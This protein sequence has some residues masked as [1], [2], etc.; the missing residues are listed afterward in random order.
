MHAAHD[1]LRAH[2]ADPEQEAALKQA[3]LTEDVRKARGTEVV[4]FVRKCS[5]DQLGAFM[6]QAVFQ[7]EEAELTEDV[8]KAREA[9]V[10]EFV[11]EHSKD[12]LVPFV[13]AIIL[14]EGLMVQQQKRA[15]N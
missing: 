5:K 4:E 1:Y 12:E 7:M 2:E 8:R 13:L 14:H 11:H 6:L 9:E 10:R 3:A 15:A